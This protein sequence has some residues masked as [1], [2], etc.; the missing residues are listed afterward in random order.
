MRIVLLSCL[1]ACV[2]IAGC[3]S[4]SAPIGDNPTLPSGSFAPNN[5]SD[6]LPAIN[7]I[8]QH[9]VRVSLTALKG[10]PVLLDFIYASCTTACPLMTSR[11][12]R[13]ADQLAADLGAK[14]T[15]VSITIDPE[16]DRPAQL[17]A[18]AKS[19]NA[20]RA[21]WLLLT[22]TP[23]DIERVMRIYR[24]TR[25]REPDGTIA[26]VTMSF[27][28]GADGRQ[29]RMYDTMEATP[30]TVVDDIHRAFSQALPNG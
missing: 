4:N 5:T 7:L 19:H 12:G 27:L 16:H 3:N 17:L 13:I 15:M 1:I 24:L 21:G 6:S 8:D 25:E 30:D 23:A 29:R 11:F 28:V 14:V 2:V 26:H 20:E 18:Y 22:G 10:N 9:G